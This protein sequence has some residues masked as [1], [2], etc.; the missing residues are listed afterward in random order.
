M[1]CCVFILHDRRFLFLLCRPFIL[2][3]LLPS[4]S[5]WVVILFL[6][7]LLTECC[8]IWKK[9][10]CAW[11]VCRNPLSDHEKQLCFFCQLC[12]VDVMETEIVPL[13]T[14]TCRVVWL[15]ACTVKKKKR[16]QTFV[17]RV[18]WRF[19][20]DTEATLLGGGLLSSLRRLHI[21]DNMTQVYRQ[22]FSGCSRVT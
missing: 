20:V 21:Y 15:Q 4:Y 5:V 9:W 22:I 2:H 17:S 6:S 18:I 8:R 14:Q 12:V 3:I 16:C 1:G 11:R 13:C 7:L 10:H 19:C